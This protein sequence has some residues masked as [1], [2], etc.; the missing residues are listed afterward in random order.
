MPGM[1]SDVASKY[2]LAVYCSNSSCSL[3]KA[4]ISTE[5]F[6]PVHLLVRYC[7]VMHCLPAILIQCPSM[8][9]PLLHYQLTHLYAFS[10]PCGS[11][12]RTIFVVFFFVELLG[13]LSRFC[14][15]RN[16]LVPQAVNLQQ[17]YGIVE[18]NVPLDTDRSFRRWGP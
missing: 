10:G 12:F 3:S 18:F 1:T 15:L 6:S 13:N 16:F 8:S 2:T 4:K 17:W 7:P 5:L 14:T 9:C 11:I